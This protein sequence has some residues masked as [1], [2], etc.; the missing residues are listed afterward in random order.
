MGNHIPLQLIIALYGVYGE[1]GS[2]VRI[3]FNTLCVSQTIDCQR[4]IELFKW[5]LR[6]ERMLYTN[7]LEVAYDFVCAGGGQYLHTLVI[8]LEM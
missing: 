3:R 7:D 8:G 4:E 1:F 5:K 2:F 6:K